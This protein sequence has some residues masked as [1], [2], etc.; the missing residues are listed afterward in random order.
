MELHVSNEFDKGYTATNL[1]K[2]EGRVQH[3]DVFRTAVLVRF[4]LP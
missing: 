2:S 1:H 4:N 3:N